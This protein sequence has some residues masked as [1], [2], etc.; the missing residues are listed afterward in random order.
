M[1]AGEEVNVANPMLAKIISS[2]NAGNIDNLEEGEVESSTPVEEVT[3]EEVAPGTSGTS[4]VVEEGIEDGPLHRRCKAIASSR[5]VANKGQKKQANKML[6]TNKKIINSIQI[7]DKVLLY[8]DGI[9]R[10]ASDPENLLCIVLEKKDIMFKLG[11]RAG[12]LDEWFPFNFF[13][14]T[15]VVT[16]FT[17]EMIPDKI[18]GKREAVKALSTGTGQGYL[19]C[20]CRAGTCKNCSCK[21]ANV[22]CNSRCHGG[23]VFRRMKIIISKILF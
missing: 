20:G 21:K 3:V 13:T 10:G 11:C 5:D 22:D 7:N 17:L 15:S 12:R 1:E 8:I 14:K 18:L 2:I 23:D 9:D 16:N 19:K 4:Q 6:A